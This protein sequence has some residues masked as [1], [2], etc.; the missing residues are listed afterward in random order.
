MF[1]LLLLYGSH[2]CLGASAPNITDECKDGK[3]IVDGKIWY[4]CVN[5]RYRKVGCY[6]L[7]QKFLYNTTINDGSVE[8]MCNVTATNKTI[9]SVTAC[10]LSGFRLELGRGFPKGNFYYTC[11]LKNMT[12]YHRITSC[13]GDDDSVVPFGSAFSTEHFLLQCMR[14]KEHDVYIRVMACIVD[15][16]PVFFGKNSSDDQYWYSCT[17]NGEEVVKEIKGCFHQNTSY[18]LGDTY[19]KDGVPHI[20]QLPVPSRWVRRNRKQKIISNSGYTLPPV[21]H[22]VET[23]G[24]NSSTAAIDRDSVMPDNTSSSRNSIHHPATDGDLVMPGN[25][26]SSRNPLHHP[27]TDKD[28]VMPDNTSSSRNSIHHPD[29]GLL[30]QNSNLPGEQHLCP[31]WSKDHGLPLHLPLPVSKQDA[32]TQT[33]W[34]G[35]NQYPYRSPN[36]PSYNLIVEYPNLREST[37]GIREPTVKQNV[38]LQTS[39]NKYSK[40]D[41]NDYLKIVERPIRLKPPTTAEETAMKKPCRYGNFENKVYNTIYDNIDLARHQQASTPSTPD[42]DRKYKLPSIEKENYLLPDKAVVSILLKLSTES[43]TLCRRLEGLCAHSNELSS[44]PPQQPHCPV[45][46]AGKKYHFMPGFGLRFKGELLLCEIDTKGN[47]ELFTYGTV[48]SHKEPK[49]DWNV[50][51]V[52]KG[53]KNKNS[54]KPSNPELCNSLE[55]PCVQYHE[56]DV[57]LYEQP[58]CQVMVF[59]KVYRFNPDF[60][61]RFKGELFL[62]VMD[63]AGMVSLFTYRTADCSKEPKGDWKVL[64]VVA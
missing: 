43:S 40:P 25:T 9:V 21:L 34:N 33:S 22:F 37:S 44:K 12:V 31:Q 50:V 60:G 47:A 28:L 24:N 58:H 55:D 10:L 38:E 54:V 63:S 19:S 3:E 15:Y 32:E 51:Q 30:M 29:S 42:T 27:T 61:M 16:N 20:C 6:F 18:Q 1:F 41:N 39:W 48:D 26:S 5:R 17:E 46:L 23:E 14:I 36:D 49:L 4:K 35:A 53:S 62:C 52:V 59:E 2:V 8:Y 64:K 13:A 11:A 7:D 56:L 57:D 45:I